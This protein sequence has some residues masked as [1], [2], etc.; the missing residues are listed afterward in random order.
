MVNSAGL[1]HCAAIV[2]SLYGEPRQKLQPPPWSYGDGR[3]LRWRRK[4][5]NKPTN[6]PGS[7]R[8]RHRG[9]HHGDQRLRGGEL[10]RGGRLAKRRPSAEECYP[11]GEEVMELAVYCGVYMLSTSRRKCRV[12]L[13]ANFVVLYL[14]KMWTSVLKQMPLLLYNLNIISSYLSLWINKH[15]LIDRIYFYNF[16]GFK[17]FLST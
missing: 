5:S 8:Q 16:P 11:W 9:D 6:V 13:Q 15:W 7:W 12:R 1:D 3:R 14:Y 2:A 4:S 17:P 10:S